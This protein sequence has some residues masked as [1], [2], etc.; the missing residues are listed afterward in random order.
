MSEA[1]GA[2]EFAADDPEFGDEIKQR[3]IT[4]CHAPENCQLEVIQ[5]GVSLSHR[6]LSLLNLQLKRP[7]PRY[8]LPPQ[9]LQQRFPIPLQ[10]RSSDAGDGAK[11]I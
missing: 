6:P 1:A 5:V 2:G 11:L 4:L 10:L 8:A 3:G 9:L 7:L